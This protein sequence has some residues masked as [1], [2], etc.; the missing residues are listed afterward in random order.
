MAIS[1][2]E[3]NEIFK[4]LPIGYYLGRDI[5]CELSE[6]IPGSY[7]DAESDLIRVA[8]KNI[9]GAFDSE[10]FSE[11]DSH[12][13]VI[14]GLLYH[15]L[16]HVLLTPQNLKRGLNRKEAD[17]VNIFEDER[18]ETLCR[19]L[20][21]NTDFRRNVVLINNY[22]GQE[23]KNAEGAFYQLVRFHKGETHWLNRVFNL[24]KKYAHINS[25]SCCFG[26]YRDAILRLYEDFVKDF[27][28][29]S[30]A[31]DEGETGEE[32]KMKGVSSASDSEGD[33]DKKSE[34]SGTENKEE[35]TGNCAG[36]TKGSSTTNNSEVDAKDES[37]SE[38]LEEALNNIKEMPDSP[39]INMP[40]LLNQ[41]V[42]QYYDPALE[43]K[44]KTIVE[45]KLKQKTKNGS[46][47][48][49]YSG[50]FNVKAVGQRDDYRWWAQQNR[51]GHIKAY[52][53]IHFN[54]II[55]N[56]GSF[57]SND[58]NMNKFIKALSRINN[59]DFTFDV[60][61][62]NTRIV[63]WPD[64]NRLFDSTG[65]NCVPPEIK[66]VLRNHRKNNAN[67][68]NIVLFD[69]DAHSDDYYSSYMKDGRPDPMLYFDT[70]NTIIITDSSNQEYLEK[71]R[72]AKIEYVS[73]YCDQFINTVC[74]LLE[75][76]L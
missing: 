76:A 61:T 75:R 26:D 37:I 66:D 8:Y 70:D 34:G 50:R 13:T 23:P 12:E 58:D 52:S 21:M 65:G 47:I 10:V 5:K 25:S 55:D 30:E 45:Q 27:E 3:V 22:T 24:I 57:C 51:T 67:N 71:A 38:A 56:S 74:K 41:C 42:N 2:I 35:M 64:H 16:S 19:D 7:Y 36:D 44:L 14:R 68:Y 63:E 6:D 72:K 20:Y 1:F 53:K 60:I 33:S 43:V 11:S 49:G 59:P 46:A 28:S 9:A 62:I 73:D 54:L 39:S 69:G 40:S 29:K 15:E 32:S 48:S 18:I 4:T 17:I 31:G